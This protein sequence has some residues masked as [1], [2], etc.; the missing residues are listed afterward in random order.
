MSAAQPS[1]VL[2]FKGALQC[3]DYYSASI[4]LVNNAA[5]ADIS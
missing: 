5:K 1:V 2:L 4:K 3:F